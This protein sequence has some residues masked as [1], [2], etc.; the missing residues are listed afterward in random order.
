ML[1]AQKRFG[2]VG[3]VKGAGGADTDHI[4]IT[5]EKLISVGKSGYTVSIGENGRSLP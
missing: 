3:R 5:A 1:S 2:G 4:Y